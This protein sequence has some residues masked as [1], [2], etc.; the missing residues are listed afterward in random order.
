MLA[1]GERR[2]HR[3]LMAEPGDAL[4]MRLA[5]GE[6]GQSVPEQ[7]TRGQRCEPGDGAQQAGFARAIRPAQQKHAARAKLKAHTLL[8]Q[9]FS[10]ENG[11]FLGSEQ[12]QKS[13]VSEWTGGYGYGLSRTKSQ[14]A[15]AERFCPMTAIGHDSLE[16]SLIH[17]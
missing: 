5:V 10:A 12:V 6:S 8:H 3:I 9:A 15:T 1:S 16:L 17:I 7:F 11:E 13:L 2:F 4:G 14:A